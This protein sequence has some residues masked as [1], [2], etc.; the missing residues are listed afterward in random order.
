MKTKESA[1]GRF[2]F[3]NGHNPVELGQE[4]ARVAD[5]YKS[6]NSNDTSLVRP[7]CRSCT[8]ANPAKIGLTS[9]FCIWTA[10]KTQSTVRSAAASKK[11]TTGICV[12]FS[13]CPAL[14]R[15]RIESA[16]RTHP[17]PY[18]ITHFSFLRVSSFSEGWISWYHFWLVVSTPLKNSQLGSLFPIWWEK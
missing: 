5:F 18:P 6:F 14:C 16:T 3:R 7:H 9:A 13:K 12:A 15:G 10:P 1:Q 11:G 8:G 17:P 4:E 2:W